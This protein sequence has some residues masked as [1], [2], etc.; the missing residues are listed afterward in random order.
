MSVVTRVERSPTLRQAIERR[1]GEIEVPA[2]DKLRH[3]LMKEGDEQRRDMGAVDVGVGHH[4]H[5]VVAQIVRAILGA[6]PTAQGLDEVGQL[7][8]GAELARARRRD[9]EDLAAQGQHRLRGAV[10]RLLGG[11]TSR[12]ALHDEELGA[13]AR[14]GRTI[15]QLAWQSQLAHG[16][17]A[18]DFTLLATTQPLF[19]AIDDPFEKLRRLLRRGSQPVVEGVAHGRLDDALSL[20]RRQPILGLTNE[21]RLADEDRK[22]GGAGDHHIVSRQ[23]GGALVARQLSVGAQAAK[24]RNAQPSLV[25]AALGRRHRVAVGVG[26]AVA[27]E[28]RHRPFDRTVLAAPRGST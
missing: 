18:A 14:V 21:L 12:V 28:P 27:R 17:F 7:L 6:R 26:E 2:G 9:V 4:D 16:R 25:R 13:G 5:L 20:G 8:V 1:H 24:Q 10:A 11:P 22:H 15:G 19:G 23:H 3:L